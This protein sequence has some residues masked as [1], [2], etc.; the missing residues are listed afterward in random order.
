MDTR[1]RSLVTSFL[2]GQ[3]LADEG[4]LRG[5]V[6]AYGRGAKL[7]EG[8]GADERRVASIIELNVRNA[9]AELLSTLGRA[10]A[11]RAAACRSTA[12]AV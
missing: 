9:R 12:P 11:A 3:S 4:D 1:I 6:A 5:A 10:G 7:C 2:E 8:L